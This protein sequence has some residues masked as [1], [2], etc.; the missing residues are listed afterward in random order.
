MRR[1]SRNQAG[2]GKGEQKHQEQDGAQ[3]P[4]VDCQRQ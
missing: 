3:G 1:G 4:A 2:E